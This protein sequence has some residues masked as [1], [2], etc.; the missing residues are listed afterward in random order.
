MM[1]LDTALHL[2]TVSIREVDM[3]SVDRPFQSLLSR[4]LHK[5]VGGMLHVVVA[6]VSSILIAILIS[7][8]PIRVFANLEAG[9]TL[10]QNEAASHE[11]NRPAIHFRLV[12]SGRAIMKGGGAAD[13]STYKADDGTLVEISIEICKSDS[14]A[15]D[16]VSA[17]TEQAKK[18]IETKPKMDNRGKVIGR[19]VVFLSKKS[20]AYVAWTEGPIVHVIESGKLDYALEF[21]NQL[22]R[23][24]LR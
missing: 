17:L 14:Q 8:Q 22:F 23:A 1:L 12:I 10:E 9:P 16:R 5:Q 4:H 24:H 18:I 15:R 11:T 20:K 6:Q 19:R 2:I 13:V 3:L 21:E 7:C